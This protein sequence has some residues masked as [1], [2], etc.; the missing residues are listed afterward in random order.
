MK[1]FI[2][3]LTGPTCAGKS[4]LEAKLRNV[5]F[6][7]L[8][9]T[10]TRA[11]RAGEVDGQHYHFVSVTH[12]IALK[13]AGRL[14]ECIQFGENFYGVTCDEIERIAKKGA[15][16]VVVVEPQGR[17][18]I[19]EYCEK[20]GWAYHAVY[21]GNPDEVIA[22]RFLLRFAEDY[23]ES[24][25]RGCDDEREFVGRYAARMKE[26]MTTERAWTCEAYFQGSM[27]GDKPYDRLLWEFNEKNDELVVLS[28]LETFRDHKLSDGNVRVAA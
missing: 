16:I 24:V 13:E 22:E 7:S 10:T 15:P 23:T 19:I 5:G 17:N 18:Q 2:V 3:I 4:T 1:P 12:F 21:V 11:P 8:T 26:M 25:M 9:S 28:I 14:V 27:D 20:A 6:E